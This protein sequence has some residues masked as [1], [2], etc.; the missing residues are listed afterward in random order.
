MAFR[1]I[2]RYQLVLENQLE[3]W[4]SSDNPVRF[5]SALVLKI[6]NDKP[7]LFQSDKGHKK[8]GRRAYNPASMLM[9]FL[10]GYLYRINSSRRLEQETYRNM[11]IIWLLGN[12]HPDHK[13][14]SDFRKDNAKLIS[15]IAKEFRMFLKSTGY[16]DGGLQ[17]YD[18][19]K[20]KACT[21]KNFINQ[22]EVEKRIA[23]IES[24]L[25]GYLKMLEEN[26]KTEDLEAAQIMQ[27][28]QEIA[29]L[30]S[31]IEELTS[32]LKDQEAFLS[33]M[34]EQQIKDYYA[35][36]PEAKR[37]KSLDGFIPAY[38]VQ[39]GVD[40]KYKMITSC[41]VS[42]DEGDQHLLADNV[43]ASKNQIEVYPDI[44][45][46]DKG[47][48]TADEI[49][50][51]EQNQVTTCVVAMP[52]TLNMKKE[53]E[54]VSFEYDQEEDCFICANNQKLVFSSRRDSKDGEILIYKVQK[55][56]C[57]QCPLF[58]KC[59]KDKKAGR[60]LQLKPNFKDLMRYRARSKTEAYQRLVEH[61]KAIIEHVFGTL[62]IWMG[63]IPFLL[64]S[65]KQVQI[66]I[67]LY[68]T[69]YNL[70]RLL[71]IGGVPELMEKL[72]NYQI[73]TV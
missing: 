26:D 50:K 25:Q 17:A 41:F 11:E 52:E 20:I 45:L 5:I 29:F 38:N 8:T 47:Y 21:N 18:G 22:R 32:Q 68:A 60:K 27:E 66:E 54:G 4:V 10:Y 64:T 56:P 63:K 49:T 71:N 12:E 15:G 34:R 3:D 48:A 19:T 69:C 2:N 51:V 1:D 14:I 28:S 6:Y 58:G 37:M 13:T 70:R 72:K 67:D 7:H 46:A 23:E 35:N 24:Q 73:M 36:D 65:K 57:K 53:A 33:M 62:K 9:L 42:T 44:A 61:R 59:T 31:Q 55:N 39:T 16:I 43:E 40:D 30:K